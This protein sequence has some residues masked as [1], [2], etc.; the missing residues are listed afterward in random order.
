MQ[1]KRIKLLVCNNILMTQSVYTV[2]LSFSITYTTT[3]ASNLHR[4][5]QIMYM[6]MYTYIMTRRSSKFLIRF[7]NFWIFNSL[8]KNK[9]KVISAG[10]MA[11]P[12][13]FRHEREGLTSVNISNSIDS[14]VYSPTYCYS[15]LFIIMHDKTCTRRFCSKTKTTLFLPIVFA[16]VTIYFE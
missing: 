8:G 16:S 11:I 9:N 5:I 1:T 10:D 13:S 4:S 14:C 2:M 7:W 12:L 15:I 3:I 6:C